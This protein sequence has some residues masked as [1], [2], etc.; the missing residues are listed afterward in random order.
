M[1]RKPGEFCIWR[2]GKK[3]WDVPM[4]R[5]KAVSV[6]LN[7]KHITSS[8]ST[9]NGFGAGIHKRKR[10]ASIHAMCCFLASELLAARCVHG[11]FGAFWRLVS[12]AA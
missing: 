10:A 11:T 4:W 7:L 9:T 8:L 1:W 5:V 6:K 12:A 3:R 2:G